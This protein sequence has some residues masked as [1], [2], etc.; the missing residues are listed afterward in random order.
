M[1]RFHFVAHQTEK[2]KTK[3]THEKWIGKQTWAQNSKYSS[4][5]VS[6]C[7][8]IGFCF[9]IKNEQQKKTTMI[10]RLMD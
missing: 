2:K 3:S 5:N 10:I 6:K 4:F 7:P 9:D 1:Q 8:T